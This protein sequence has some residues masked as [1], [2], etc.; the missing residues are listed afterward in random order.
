MALNYHGGIDQFQFGLFSNSWMPLTH[1]QRRTSDEACVNLNAAD[2]GEVE[3]TA[4]EY[5][6]GERK[7]IHV[8]YF[9][10]DQIFLKS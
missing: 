1:H 10:E 2:E 6:W 9:I 8:K 3:L 4:H 5:F 7:L